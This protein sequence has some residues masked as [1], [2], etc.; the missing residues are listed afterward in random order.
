MEKLFPKYHEIKVLNY[1]VP[2]DMVNYQPVKKKKYFLFVGMNHKIKNI[3]FLIKVFK[4]FRKNKKNLDYK[5]FLVGNLQKFEDD[6]NGIYTF[7]K[8]SR[9]E[10]K[11]LYSEASAYLTASF[12]E[13]FN[14]P[15]LEAL[16]QNCPVIGLNG[17]I[18]PEFNDYVY[19]AFDSTDFLNHMLTITQNKG[20][21]SQRE[22]ILRQFSWKKYVDKLKEL[23]A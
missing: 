22:A 4:L 3:E 1:G 11:K 23:Y 20:F 13:S 21:K 5:F 2:V 19:I 16:S 8:V 15:V 18:I 7:P 17:S 14:F 12:Y 9:S 6:K 10:V